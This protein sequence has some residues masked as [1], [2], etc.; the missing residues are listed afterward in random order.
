MNY[1]SIIVYIQKSL[2]LKGFSHLS[3]SVERKRIFPQPALCTVAEPSGKTKRKQRLL[4]EGSLRLS[5]S[6]AWDLTRFALPRIGAET[7]NLWMA[8]HLLF[9]SC[10]VMS[11]TVLALRSS[12]RLSTADL[13]ASISCLIRV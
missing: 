6:L 11:S 5:A 7:V 3:Y 1:C 12:R 10:S 2:W 8:G 13:V 4:E 9:K